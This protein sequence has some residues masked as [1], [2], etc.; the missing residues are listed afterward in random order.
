MQPIADLAIAAGGGVGILFWFLFV[1]VTVR[2]KQMLA[3][4]PPAGATE[5][6]HSVPDT[7][8]RRAAFDS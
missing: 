7:S 2:R 1:G 5:V 3:D 4:L 6:G 8:S